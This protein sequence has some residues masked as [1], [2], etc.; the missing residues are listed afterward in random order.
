MVA[1]VKSGSSR[2][3]RYAP[4]EV[5]LLFR[6]PLPVDVIPGSHSGK[7]KCGRGSL[8]E[9]RSLLLLSGGARRKEGTHS[10]RGRSVGGAGNPAAGLDLRELEKCATFYF[11]KGL[12]DSSQ[13]TYKSGENRYLHFCLSCKVTPLP[14]SESIL[15]KFVSY[16]A[17]EGLKHR[18]IKTYLS[19]VRYLQIRSGFPD[20]FHGSHMPRLD[21]T[22]RGVKRVES[23]RGG[24][25]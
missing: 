4:D 6:S 1:I 15:C 11:A 23:E 3:G 9:G 20:P 19:G 24:V 25:V 13:R 12:A 5:P 16:L 7:V 14:V 2:S 17:C 22:V 8:I 18:S 10:S 21:Y